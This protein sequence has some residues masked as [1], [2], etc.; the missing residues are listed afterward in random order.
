[1]KQGL[2]G[3]IFILC[4]IYTLLLAV[5]IIRHPKAFNCSDKFICN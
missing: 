2:L 3:A 5:F 4:V 1:M